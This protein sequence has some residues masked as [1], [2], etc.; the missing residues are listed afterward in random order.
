MN[1]PQFCFLSLSIF[2]LPL[3]RS[4]INSSFILFSQFDLRLG[5]KNKLLCSKSFLSFNLLA[6]VCNK[7]FHLKTLAKNAIASKE[8][9]SLA[10]VLPVAFQDRR[11]QSH[12]IPD[13]LKGIP[14]AKDPLFFEMVEYFFHKGCQVVEASP[15]KK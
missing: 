11:Y 13:R 5:L 1:F 10:R 15:L 14:D 3:R 8:L 7:M 4:S 2:S 9:K 6:F 12:Q